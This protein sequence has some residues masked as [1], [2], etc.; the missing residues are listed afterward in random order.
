MRFEEYAYTRVDMNEFE[1]EFKNLLESFRTANSFEL[2]DNIMTQIN[3]MRNSF[4]TMH[5]LVSIRHSIN[6][7][8]EF[9]DKE[10]EYYDN[11]SPIYQGLIDTFYRD[12][13]S[14]N[15][16]KELEEKWG[17][18]LFTIAE[19]ALKT[20]D[21]AIIPDLQEENKLTSLYGKLLASA[22]IEFDGKINNLSQMTPYTQSMNRQTR[23]SASEAVTKFFED[24]EKDLDEIYDKLVKLRHQMALKLGYENYVKLGYLRLGRSEYG[25]EE[26]AIFRRQVE[27]NLVPI[28]VE[29]RKRQADRLGIDQLM[30]YDENL[31]YN[32]GNAKP[33]GDRE[34]MVKHATT[35]YAELSPETKEFFDFMVEKNLLDLDSKPGKRAGGYCTYI[36]DYKSPFIFANFNGTSHDVDVLTHEA[37]HAFQVYSSRQYQVPEYMWPT[38]EACEIHSMSMEFLTWPWMNLFFE[39]DETKYKFSHLAAGVLFIPYGVTVDEFQ[40]FV[41][42]NPDASPEE[43]KAKWREVERKYLPTKN[44]EDN[45]FLEKGGFWFRQGH[46]FGNPF[47][48]IDYTLAQI[49]AY[50][51]W[52]KYNEN[53][54]E[55]WQDYLRLCKAGGSQP[56]LELVKYAKLKSPFEEDTINFVS[57]PIRAWLDKIDDKKM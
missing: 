7:N 52:I 32:S 40:H 21:P 37:G 33:K 53:P 31:E 10:N 17:N 4:E 36:A 3:E 39:N 6:T 38:L 43:R 11:A 30:Y 51:F 55:A 54:K 42:E 29:L 35:M 47:Y 26:V 56:F 20:F 13:V 23:K 27:K 24:N 12:L 34:W 2:Q 25:P 45:A 16:R 50:Q 5:A 28:T 14:S 19:T 1:K 9:Y 48:Y 15:F 18:L 41:Y 22:K 44:Y 49:C 57:K 46:I 8:D